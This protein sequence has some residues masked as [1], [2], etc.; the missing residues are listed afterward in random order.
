MADAIPAKL[1]ILLGL[2]LTQLGSTFTVSQIYFFFG[3]NRCLHWVEEN[4]AAIS[5]GLKFQVRNEDPIQFLKDAF[6]VKFPAIR[7]IPTTETE[8]NSIIHSLKS[9]ENSSG[10]DEINKILKTCSDLISCSLTHICDRLC[11]LVVSV[12]DY[13]HR[14]PRFDSRALFRIFL[15]ESGLERG[16]LNLV[17]G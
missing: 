2:S 15:R 14:G 11:G 5:E 17:I 12:A 4:F 7:I 9:K 8:I 13:K 16:P 3:Q 1:A 10:F 6:P